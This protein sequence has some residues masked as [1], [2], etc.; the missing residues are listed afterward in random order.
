MAL[1]N[2]LAT[3]ERRTAATPDTPC[4]PVKVSAK[5]API[6][7]CTP[8]TRDT[9]RNDNAVSTDTVPNPASGDVAALREAGNDPKPTPTDERIADQELF[10]FSQA[11]GKVLARV[12]DQLSARSRRS[13]APA[14]A[15]AGEIPEGGRGP[16]R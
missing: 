6:L 3:M 16:I 5:P 15:I 8:D 12:P 13:T 9:P 7:A 11:E 10:T 4:N 2:L 1:K 14:R